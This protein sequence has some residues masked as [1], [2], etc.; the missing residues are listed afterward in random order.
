MP[1]VG[2]LAYLLPYH[3]PGT[4]RRKIRSAA[5]RGRIGLLTMLVASWV[6]AYC[7]DLPPLSIVGWSL[8]G[9]SASL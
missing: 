5:S 9:T 8:E 6:P 4:P 7:P 1:L 2:L 3:M